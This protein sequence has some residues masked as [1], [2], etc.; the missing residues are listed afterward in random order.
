MR[1]STSGTR[2]HLTHIQCAFIVRRIQ[3]L[4]AGTT[5]VTGGCLGVDT[6]IA[7]T[8]FTAGLYVHTIMPADRRQAD[9]DWRKWCHTFKEMPRGT[10][11]RQ[12]DE[13]VVEDGDNLLAF[14]MYKEWVHRTKTGDIRSMRSGTWMTVR[15]AQ[16]VG[17]SVEVFVL[18]DL[19]PNWSPG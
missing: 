14:P 5:V 9:P 1:V 3:A 2:E 6:L 7:T 10:T 17:K 8:A 19:P 18:D 15:I 4:P 12:R 16:K 13:A 11:M